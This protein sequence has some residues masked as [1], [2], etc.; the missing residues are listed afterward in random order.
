MDLSYGTYLWGWPVIQVIIW[1]TGNTIGSLILF[2]FSM[3]VVTPIAALSW[4]LIEK[5]CLDLR[6]RWLPVKKVAVVGSNI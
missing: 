5:P 1:M 3:L 6:K 2:V 4:M